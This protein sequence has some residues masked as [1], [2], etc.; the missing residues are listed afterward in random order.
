MQAGRQ[1]PQHVESSLSP[2]V[3]GR[4]VRMRR[5][6]AGPLSGAPD[7]TFGRCAGARANA[8]AM[9]LDG[10]GG[11][12]LT[13]GEAGFPQLYESGFTESPEQGMPPHLPARKPRRRPGR[14]VAQA[15]D[16]PTTAAPAREQAKFST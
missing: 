11:A 12:H 5:V 8:P 7:A 16:F 13:P 2:V 15:L 6:R 3:W 1:V 4:R 14:A 9:G 10:R